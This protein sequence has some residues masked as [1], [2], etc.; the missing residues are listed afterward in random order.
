MAAGLRGA[1][2]GARA[3]LFRLKRI[4]SVMAAP[5]GTLMSLGAH[6]EGDGVAEAVEEAVEEG[7]IA[8]DMVVA[9]V[10]VGTDE[11]VGCFSMLHS[12]YD[13]CEFRQS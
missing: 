13:I 8:V 4:C 7:G 10:V 3:V 9:G 6:A 5:K 1:I 2:W 11:S 12:S